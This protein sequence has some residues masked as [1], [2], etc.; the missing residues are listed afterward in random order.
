MN[1]AYI[2]DGVR[3]PIGNFGGSLS[4]V[5]SDDLGA[6]VLK[7]LMKKNPNLDYS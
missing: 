7:A 6:F 2:V 5:R 1:A 4:G 3:T